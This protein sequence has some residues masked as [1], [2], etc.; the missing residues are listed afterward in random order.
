MTTKMS[1]TMDAYGVIDKEVKPMG[2]NG[3]RVYLPEEWVGKKVRVILTEKPE[4]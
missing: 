3:G 4:E 1:I 2:K